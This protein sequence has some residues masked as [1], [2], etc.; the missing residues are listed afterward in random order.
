MKSTIIKLSPLLAEEVY[1]HTV[2]T[3]L[4][5]HRSGNSLLSADDLALY[6]KLEKNDSTIII[7]TLGEAK[8]LY[9]ELYNLVDLFAEWAEQEGVKWLAVRKA[10]FARMKVLKDLGLTIDER[11]WAR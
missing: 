5:D 8:S 2:E 10:A 1:G 7:E 4:V 9:N 3:G 11:G 6:E